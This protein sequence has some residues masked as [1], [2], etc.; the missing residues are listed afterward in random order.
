MFYTY[1]TV[2]W[3]VNNKFNLSKCELKL[4]ITTI[5]ELQQYLQM[6]GISWVKEWREFVSKNKTSQTMIKMVSVSFDREKL[7]RT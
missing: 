2:L 1:V 6:Q 7:Q 4:H 3:Q 5:F